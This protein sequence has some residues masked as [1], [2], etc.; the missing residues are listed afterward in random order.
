METQAVRSV[1]GEMTLVAGCGG[2]LEPVVVGAGVWVIPIAGPASGTLAGMV[3]GIVGVETT[4]ALVAP[5][6]LVG[7][8]SDGGTPLI[9]M[10]TLQQHDG[11]RGVRST[12][13]QKERML[14]RQHF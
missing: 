8:A 10:V 13:N 5:I 6:G 1:K 12:E 2:F 11:M 14:A 3:G 4:V 9:M 7:E